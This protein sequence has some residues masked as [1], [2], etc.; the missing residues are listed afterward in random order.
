M[1][2]TLGIDM[3]NTFHFISA[4]FYGHV[5]ERDFFCCSAT[6]V[7]K[8]G[9]EG[10]T[11]H[12]AIV[13]GLWNQ[14]QERL[15][16]EGAFRAR[17]PAR[18]ARSGSSPPLFAAADFAGVVET[19]SPSATSAPQLGEQKAS[20]SI[21]QGASRANGSLRADDHQVAE[22]DEVGATVSLLPERATTEAAGSDELSSE[23]PRLDGGLQGLVSY[24]RWS[25]S[26][27]LDGADRKSV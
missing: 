6:A 14:S 17:R 24:P 8:I 25:A 22:T 5:V 21:V 3:G 26:G 16:M 9:F 4:A 13:S 11:R 10:P 15:Q 27:T 1:G 2:N 19:D 20:K 12:V 23:Q 18:S 7:R